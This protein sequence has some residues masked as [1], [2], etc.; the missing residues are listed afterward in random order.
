MPDIYFKDSA[1]SCAVDESVLDTLLRHNIAIP[2]GCRAG[3]CQA[4]ILQ[5]DHS[6]IPEDCQQGL[7]AQHLKQDY[8]LACQCIPE[9][10]MQIKPV[11]TQ[12]QKINA[13]VSEKFLFNERTL[14]LRL[15]CRLRWR[16]GQ[17]ITL[18]IDNTARCY[19]IASVAQLDP[20]IELHIRAYPNGAISSQLFNS[21]KVGDSLQIQGP[22]GSFVYR[23]DNAEQKLL[24]IGA[25]TGVA[26]LLGI[27]RDALHHQHTANIHLLAGDQTPISYAEKAFQELQNSTAQFSY[28]SDTV[29]NIDTLLKAQFSTLRG[30][31]IYIC[32]G[33]SF[34]QKIRKSCFMLGASPRDIITEAFINFSNND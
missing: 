5:A 19:S 28:Q 24:L 22:L 10:D 20:L 4:C 29:E 34:V 33:E 14:R 25:G 18:W 27:I 9:Q 1:Y 32:G 26:P 30:Q 8:F 6:Q 3:A 12:T 16:A 13:N 17:Y 11:D 23:H 7:S 2:Y 21:I 15:S 31:R